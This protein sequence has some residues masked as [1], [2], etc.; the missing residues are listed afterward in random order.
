MIETLDSLPND[1]DVLQKMVLQ[2]RKMYLQS[3]KQLSLK[4][5]QLLD[6]NKVL[7]S[8]EASIKARDE[9]IEQL[10]E[11]LALLR[12]KRFQ[13]QSEQLKHIQGQ[14]FNEAEL[15]AEIREVEEALAKIQVTDADKIK[16]DPMV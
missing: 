13:S 2:S 10:M 12:S 3:Q 5:Q 4:D 11:Q 7:A 6:L 1:P 16:K 14:L 15:E 8:K 9:T